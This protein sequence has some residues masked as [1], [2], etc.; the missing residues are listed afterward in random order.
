MAEASLSGMTPDCTITARSTAEIV[1]AAPYV[2]GFHPADSVVVIGTAGGTITFGMRYDLPPPGATGED[3]V[4]RLVA[5]QDLAN[6]TVIGYGPPGRVTPAVLRL[7]DSLAHAGVRVIDVLR[8]GEGRWWSYRCADLRCCPPD[9]RPVDTSLPAAAVFQ[10]LVALPDRQSLVAQVA[11]VAGAARRE[12]AVATERAR[13]PADPRGTVRT[14]EAAFRSGRTP[15][16]DQVAVLGV[17]LADHG[18]LEYA[19]NRTLRTGDEW[20]VRL[21]TEVLRRVEPAYVPGPACLLALAAWRCGDGSL[22]R[23]AVD[24]ALKEDPRH[25]T[26]VVLDDLLSAGIGPAAMVKLAPP[27]KRAQRTR[28]GRVFRR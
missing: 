28:A 15:T 3:E 6:A 17:A 14:A 26:A 22:A 11:P 7:A 19:L 18:V 1:A 24:R 27:R 10:G 13:R 16:A 8:V 4:A 25:P 2:I 9:G 21:W 20:R 23:V 12:M 5:R